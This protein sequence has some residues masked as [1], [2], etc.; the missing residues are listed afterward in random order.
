MP[1]QRY[2]ANETTQCESD[3]LSVNFNL[4]STSSVAGMLASGRSNDMDGLHDAQNA[5]LDDYFSNNGPK[6]ST[7]CR[8]FEHILEGMDELSIDNESN[9]DFPNETETLINV[10]WT[11][12]D[13]RFTIATEEQF[14]LY[15]QMLFI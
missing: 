7:E 15:H 10:G 2:D 13:D 14:F 3:V 4:N 12:D 8:I 11:M 6:T 9:D 5:V 1:T